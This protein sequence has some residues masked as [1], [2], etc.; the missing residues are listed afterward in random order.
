MWNRIVAL[1]FKELASIWLDKRSRFFLFGPPLM[2]L[3]L[4]SSAATLEVK[5]NSIGILNRDSGKFSSEL[6]E[7]F[8]G[9]P[10]F[11]KIHFLYNSKEMVEMIENEEISTV[12]QIDDAFSRN[13]LSKKPATV[14]MI[15]DGKRSNSAQIVYSYAAAIVGQ[16]NAD[17]AKEYGLPGPHSILVQRDFYNPNLTYTWFTVPGLV[18]LLSMLIALT[19]TALSIS[20]EKEMGTF[21]QL[22]VTPLKPIEILIG[23]TIPAI[24][25][26]MIEATFMLLAAIF[27]FG[28][29]FTGSIPLLYLSLFVF[30]LSIIGIGLFI[31]SVARTQQQAMLGVF[32]FMSPAVALSGFATPIENTPEWIQ[33]LTL[34]NP[35]RYFLI[36]VR[37]S[38]LKELS[39]YD[40]LLNIYPMLLI[41]LFTLS[42]ST[43]FFTRRLS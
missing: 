10:F 31:S 39:A 18:G 32:I 1:L 17:L 35:I 33:T 5:N 3:I 21:E 30:I 14:Q 2:Q 22:L 15:L 13:I 23:K 43:W 41:A 38:F 11:T 40:V 28:I 19:I 12:I 20:R 9:S 8:N 16:F 25:I 42:G 26:G 6:I 29:P 27:I 4:F 34:A 24:L 37:G 36:I 7:R